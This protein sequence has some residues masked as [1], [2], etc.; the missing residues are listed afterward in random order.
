VLFRSIPQKKSHFYP[1]LA[2]YNLGNNRPVKLPDFIAALEKALG[3]SAE[4][5]FLAMQPGDVPVTM[6]DIEQTRKD[7]NW[8]PKTAI[9]TGLERFAGWLLEY[10]KQKA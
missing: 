4:K 2:V 9:D 5:I 10:E 8:Q 6:A 3:R 7:L 1:A